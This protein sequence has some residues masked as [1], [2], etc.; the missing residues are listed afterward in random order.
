M[1]SLAIFVLSLLCIFCTHSSLHAYPPD[2]LIALDGIHKFSP[3]DNPHYALPS[4]DDSGWEP[5]AVPGNW[6]S[7]GISP[8]DGIGWYRIHCTVPESFR[9][10]QPAVFL[11]RIGDADEVFFNGFMIGGEGSIG[12]QF[13]EA[14]KIDRLYMIPREQINYGGEN[15][16]AVRVLNT[17]LNGGIFDRGIHIGEYKDLLIVKLQ[18]HQ[19][20][21]IGEFCFFTFFSLFFLACLFFYIK[22]LRDREYFYFWLFITLYGILFFLGSVTFYDTGMKTRSVQ[23]T[24]AIISALLPASLLLLLVHFY[25]EKISF[26][27]RTIAA[28]FFCIATL[29]LFFTSYTA[30]ISLHT[31]WKLL[32]I[33]TA[34]FLVFIAIKAFFRKFYESGTILF[35]ITGLIVGFIVESLGGLDLLQVTGFF[36]WDYAVAFFM[37]C[38]MYALTSRYTRIKEL[39]SASMKIFNAHEKERKRLAR[40]LHDGIGTSLLAT[41]MKLKMIEARVKENLPIDEQAFP[42][43]IAEM[44]HSIDEL[45]AVAKDLRPSFLENTELVDAMKWHARKVQA[46]TGIDVRISAGTLNKIG[47]ELKENLYRIFQEALNNAIKHSGATSVDILLSRDTEYLTLEIHDNGR[48]FVIAG[49]EKEEQGLGLYTIRERVELLGGIIRIKSSDKIG[50]N[51]YIEVPLK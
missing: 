25:K 4:Y 32:F 5:V 30:R 21:L 10:I 15:L 7:Q 43:L 11:G 38:V 41:K 48:G 49:R 40:E 13:I 37:I 23:Q 42:E 35:G 18:K 29:S 3:D 1:N 12:K 20:T 27:V 2:Y 46:R 9:N 50:T 39:Q 28:A 14:S 44:R 47:P 17:Y 16:I 22:G 51:I 19:N 33:L 24:I 36:L 8:P 26:F 45:R 31:F 34:A 6:Q